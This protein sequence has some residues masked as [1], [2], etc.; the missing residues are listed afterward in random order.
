MDETPKPVFKNN[1]YRKIAQ[2]YI[3]YLVSVKREMKRR[4]K[5]K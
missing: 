2:T 1:F 3:R 4:E 5:R